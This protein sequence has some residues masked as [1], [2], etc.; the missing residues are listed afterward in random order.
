M[1][2]V[3]TFTPQPRVQYVISYK[4]TEDS[5]WTIPPNNPTTSSPFIINGLTGGERYDFKIETSCG[6]ITTF[7]GTVPCPAVSSLTATNL[8]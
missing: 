7:Q 3:I 5:V 1:A 2:A 6:D 8:I 4:E